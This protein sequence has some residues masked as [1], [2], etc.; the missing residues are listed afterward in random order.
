MKSA[1]ER[2]CGLCYSN[3]RGRTN[4]RGHRGY[5]SSPRPFRERR[6]VIERRVRSSESGANAAPSAL[7]CPM[8]S[9][10]PRLVEYLV[11][12]RFADGKKRQTSTLTLFLESGRVKAAL[13]DRAE[14][15]SLWVTAESVCKAL[16][17]LEAALE[18]GAPDWRYWKK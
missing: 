17:C 3:V 4:A 16:D 11:S 9:T 5:K 14:G 13:N 10:T 7:V 1:C 2:W 12:D 8:L 18:D 15:C 6:Q